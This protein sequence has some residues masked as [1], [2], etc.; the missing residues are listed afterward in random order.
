WE[1]PP[2]AGTV[3][4][5]DPLDVDMT[6]LLEPPDDRLRPPVVRVAIGHAEMVEADAHP[7]ERVVEVLVVATTELARGGSLCL[8]TDHDRRPVV[9]RAADEEDLVAPVAQI[10]DVHVRRHVR[11]EVTEVART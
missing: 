9:V 4:L 7:A 8:G 5:L 3:T 2:A 1:E 6:V 10:A 11:A